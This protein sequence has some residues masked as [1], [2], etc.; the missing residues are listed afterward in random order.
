M[1]RD[2]LAAPDG[3]D[4]LV[5]LAL[6]AD[7]RD[8]DVERLCDARAHLIDR[9]LDLRPLENHG[10]VQ[11]ADLVAGAGRHRA[12]GGEQDEAVGP[13]PL[14]VAVGKL[15]ADVAETGRA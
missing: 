13:L 8:V 12:R 15:P 7:A 5:G 10:D 9:I 3:V 6:D 4:T 14:R 2:R 11:V 1:S